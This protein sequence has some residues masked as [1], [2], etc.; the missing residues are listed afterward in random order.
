MLLGNLRS[1]VARN[2]GSLVEEGGAW[3]E[4]RVAFL[5]GLVPTTIGALLGYY[6]PLWG[7]I[8]APLISAIG[9]LT[10]FSINAIVLLSGNLGDDSY[11]LE[12]KHLQQTN[13]L[14]LY[15]ILVG[16]CLLIVLV[17]GVVT[18]NIDFVLQ[19]IP[20]QYRI[21]TATQVLSVV[22]YSL[23]CHYF[24]VLL[25]VTH[26]LYTLVHSGSV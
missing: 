20:A 9:V 12:Q 10:G 7:E 8:I 16:F 5:F 15:S 22:V 23:T 21:V 14:T 13:D 18:A 26:R 17:F 4:T 6:S 1:I 2:Y 19:E 3:A 25:S 24:V 11:P